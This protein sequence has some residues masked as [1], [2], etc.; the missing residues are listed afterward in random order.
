MK[1]MQAIT[2]TGPGRLE[3]REV[4]LPEP[5]AGQAR[6]RTRA[7][8]VCS[9]DLKMIAG[10]QRT[11]FPAIP[12]HEWCGTVDAL[13]PGADPGLIGRLCVGEN[14][15]LDGGEVGFEH[16]GGYGEFFL[17]EAGL[18]YPLPDDFPPAQGALIE[19]LAVCLRGLAR[20]R[21][22]PEADA[23]VFGDGPI[24]LLMLL[25]LRQSGPGRVALV[26]HQPNRLA[27]ARW[28]GADPIIDGTALPSGLE[29]EFPYLVEA[30]GSPEALAWA[31]YL[32]PQGG[33]ILVLGDYD[34]AQASFIWN[35]LLHR[36]LEL[37]GSN[38]SAEAWPEAVALAVTGDLPLDRLVTHRFPP[39]QFAEAIALTTHGKESC[40]KVIIEWPP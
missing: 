36:E 10:W 3:L 26:G 40:I 35:D 5:G 11:G 4:P 18:L 21:R 1:T 15:L 23:L 2:N 13:G 27:L 8:A 9:T 31:L 22:T 29:G 38:A 37:V 12:G 6:I 24:G 16:P 34:Q 7:V 28:F 14:V 19:P 25:A 20:L 32:A 33:R 17:T 30:S 39:A